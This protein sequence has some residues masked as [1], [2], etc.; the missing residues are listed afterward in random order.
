MDIFLRATVLPDG[1]GFVRGRLQPSLWE[2]DPLCF[3]RFPDV[4]LVWVDQEE[5]ALI[6]G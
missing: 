1:N 2:R 6:Q 4:G 3:S 5:D